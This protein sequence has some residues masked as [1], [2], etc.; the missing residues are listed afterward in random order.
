M[1]V[2]LGLA[3]ALVLSTVAAPAI[4]EKHT[5][6]IAPRASIGLVPLNDRTLTETATITVKPYDLG[7]PEGA[8]SSPLP[9]HCLMS[10]TVEL[11]GEKVV[12]QPGKVICISDQRVPLEA[13][14]DGE[15]EALGSCREDG[16]QGC[17]RYVLR[18]EELGRLK[19]R[20]TAV[21]E[22][23]PRNEQN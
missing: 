6:T 5:I 1:N 13:I 12:L 14:P 2:H 19:L 3:L 16:S 23:Q 15:I 11:D 17:A 22:P 8:F 21:L 18:A 9:E 20:S 4:A 7:S 10:V